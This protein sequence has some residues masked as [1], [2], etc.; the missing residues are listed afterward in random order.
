MSLIRRNQNLVQVLKM[1]EASLKPQAARFKFQATSI[2]LHDPFPFIKFYEVK[3]KGLNHDECMIRMFHMERNLMR[4]E[5]NFVCF[6][7]F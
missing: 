3:T 7:C 1:L 5:A 2:K 4:G 6:R